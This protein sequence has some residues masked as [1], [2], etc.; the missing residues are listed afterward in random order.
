M[1]VVVGFHGTDIRTANG[2]LSGELTWEESSNK[3][4]WLGRGIYFWQDD[5]QRAW[6]FAKEPRRGWHPDDAAVIEAHI[7]LGNCLDLVGRRYM[8]LLSQAYQILEEQVSKEGR[9]LPSN[10]GLL[11]DLDAFVVDYVA[12]IWLKAD[13]VRA[14]FLEGD[15]VYPGASFRSQQHIQVAVRNP[16]SIMDTRLIPTGA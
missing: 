15:E 10:R 3:Y 14:V 16:G 6:E 1:A 2:L 4:D 8:T 13:T 11:H 5:E 7:E 12:D 9:T